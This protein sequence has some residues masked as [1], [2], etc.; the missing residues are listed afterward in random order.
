VN[1]LIE[2]RDR[3]IS[4][5]IWAAIGLLIVVWFPLLLLIRALDRNEVHYRTGRWFRR[6]GVAMAW[7][8]PLCRISIEGE[9][10]ENPRLPFLVVSNHQ[11]GGDIPVISHLPWEMKWMGKKE[12]FKLPFVGWMMR[13]AGDIYLDRSSR[14][15][16]ARA[17]VRARWYLDRHCSVIIFPE[18]TRSPDGRLL[19]FK[20]GAFA[21]AIKAGVPVLPLVVQGSSNCLPKKSWIFR[22][23]HHITVTVLPPIH[24][25]GMK[26][27]DAGRLMK[28]V[29][30]AM[31]ECL[32]QEDDF[33]ED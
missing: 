17:M 25:H 26:R 6:L 14:S 22:G 15:S 16:G 21:L 30:T 24:T 29:R 32:Q 28:M 27:E 10:I 12:L 33:E 13:I 20:S 18:G 19:P 4:V 8:N 5:W 31:L 9:H 1:L 23:R 7:A 3:L 2:F 11:S